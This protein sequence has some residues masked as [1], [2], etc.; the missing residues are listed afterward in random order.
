[1]KRQPTLFDPKDLDR[2]TQDNEKGDVEQSR[3]ELA[4][5]LSRQLSHGG[6]TKTIRGPLFD[7]R[8]S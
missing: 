2:I 3:R 6:V 1:M 4:K 7:E 5:V 8:Q